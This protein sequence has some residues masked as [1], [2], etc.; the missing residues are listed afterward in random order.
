[1]GQTVTKS[2]VGGKLAANDSIYRIN[3]LMKKSDPRGLSAPPQR[4]Y[5]CISPPFS[6]IFF[7][8]TTW[9][10]KAKFYVEPRWEGGEYINGPGLMTKMAAIPIYGITFKNLFLQN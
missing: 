6:K 10:I 4:L 7:S 8:K 3:M 2:F 9:P 1:M 5:T